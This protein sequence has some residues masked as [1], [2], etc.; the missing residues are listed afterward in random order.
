MTGEE[1]DVPL[2]E[3][4]EQDSFLQETMNTAL[5]KELYNFLHSKGMWRQNSFCFGP[6]EFEPSQ[7][8][9]N[10]AITIMPNK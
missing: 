8:D 1:E 3:E 4:Q 2:Q 10:A 6:C 9:K 7:S 5:G